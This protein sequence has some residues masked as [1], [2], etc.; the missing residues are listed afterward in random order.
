MRLQRAKEAEAGE[1]GFPWAGRNPVLLEVVRRRWVQYDIDGTIQAPGA[2]HPELSIAGLVTPLRKPADVLNASSS[3]VNP[4]MLPNH[5]Y[6]HVTPISA[7]TT[8][9]SRTGL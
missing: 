3:T 2:V 4:A 8:S 9:T 5:R 7:P 1:P 6:H